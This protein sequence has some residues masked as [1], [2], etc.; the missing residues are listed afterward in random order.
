M[1]LTDLEFYDPNSIQP[2]IKKNFVT[3]PNLPRKIE[4]LSILNLPRKVSAINPPSKQSMK[5]VP[6]KLVTVLAEV[7]L[8]KCMVAV[9]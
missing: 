4:F 1:D 7:A 5:E 6:R 9:K 8:P 2:T 3:Q